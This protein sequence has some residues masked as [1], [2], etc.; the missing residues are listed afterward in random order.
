MHIKYVLYTRLSALLNLQHPSGVFLEST[1][2]SDSKTAT[3]HTWP[4]SACKAIRQ[5][6]QFTG[7]AVPSVPLLSGPYSR[8]HMEQLRWGET[9]SHWAG[10][11]FLPGL[12]VSCP[13]RAKFSCNNSIRTSSRVAAGDKSHLTQGSTEPW[14]LI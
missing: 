6:P 9:R 2:P 13:S 14:H 10:A 5:E 11:G 1:Q 8:P 4:Q 3:G 12:K 7:R